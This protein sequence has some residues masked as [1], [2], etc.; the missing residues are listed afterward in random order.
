MSQDPTTIFRTS[1]TVKEE[2]TE[3]QKAAAA[4]AAEEATKKKTKSKEEQF[5]ELKKAK[6]DAEKRLADFQKEIDEKYKPL[7][8]LVPVKTIAEYIKTKEGR[9]DE[10]AVNNFIS[11]QKGR[12]Q[13]LTESEKILQEKEQRLK[14]I[15]IVE[16]DEWK[17]N[18]QKPIQ[19]AQTTLYATIANV[20]ADGTI[21]HG[22]LV[23]HLAK[24]ILKIDEKTGEPLSAPQI[25]A[26]LG[27]FAEEYEK[28][29]GEEYEIPRINDVVDS[30]RV[31]INRYKKAADAKI[32]WEKERDKNNKEKLF[33]KAKEQEELI[34]KE[35]KARD[36]QIN[37]FIKGYDFSTIEGVIE[38]DDLVKEIKS[39][40]DYY[41]NVMK[42]PSKL[43]REY[44]QNVELI[45]KGKL[46]DILAQ[47][48][49]SLQTELEK[50]N[51]KIRSGLPSGGQ[52]TGEENNKKPMFEKGKDPTS[53]FK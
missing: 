3:E 37:E 20:D 2:L 30:V 28:K 47:K 49:K 11:R 7:E 48:V 17:E 44:H 32:N 18:Y 45:S 13:K 51:E 36:Y 14:E 23:D 43:D 24:S 12:K 27:K 9:L 40:H 15:S 41:I 22:N 10:E 4:A 46:F 34:S 35:V 8:E 6:E 53:I 25:K 21:K 50:A 38:K 5:G 19:D 52:K 42:D 39:Q 26:I 31:F 16:S 33:H 1:A 29:T